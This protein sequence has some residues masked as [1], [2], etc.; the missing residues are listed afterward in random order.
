MEG[1]A[2]EGLTGFL[3]IIILFAIFYFLL[4]RPQQ[5]KAKE[6]KEMVAA[7]RKGQRVV[8]SSGIYGTVQSIDDTTVGLE[9]AD[10]VKVKMVRTNVAAV[11]SEG[12][13]EKDK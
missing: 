1:G 8:T 6:H 4:I 12:G 5:K 10:N 13:G 7:L 11:L 3:P 9:I 2:L